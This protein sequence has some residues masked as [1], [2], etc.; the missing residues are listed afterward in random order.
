MG[1][2][3]DKEILRLFPSLIFK[4]RVA[5]EAI[6]DHAIGEINLLMNQAP[7]QRAHDK[8]TTADNLQ[9]LPQFHYLADLILKESNSV[10]DFFAVA[11][12]S[13][14]ITNMW[15]HV[16]KKGHRHAA[17]IH[18]NS[19]L[20]GIVYLQTPINCGNTI[21]LDPRCGATIIHPDFNEEN[22][23]NMNA[24]IHKPVKGS[25]LIWN[26]WLPHMVDQASE[27]DVNHRIVIA[28]NIMIKGAV[29][30]LSEQ[31]VY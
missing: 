15:A 13:H 21:F 14:Y 1:E 4:G 29:Q 25:M 23:F 30:R 8:F 9:D 6:I 24:F 12:D 7:A 2:L 27:T 3:I 10:L 11:R 18:P 26:S 19:Y 5:D 22:Y 20:S 16:T 28:F 31:I 17:H